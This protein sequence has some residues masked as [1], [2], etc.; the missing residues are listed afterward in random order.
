LRLGGF[1]R[2]SGF[3]RAVVAAVAAAG[4]SRCGGE[5]EPGGGFGRVPER[6]SRP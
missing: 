5:D 6:V 1:D 3:G 2:S 4:V